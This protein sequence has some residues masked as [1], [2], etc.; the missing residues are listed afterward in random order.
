MVFIGVPMFAPFVGQGL[1]LLSGWRT[2]FFSL[3]VFSVVT[4]IWFWL[5]QPETLAP[6]NKRSLEFSKIILTLK[7]V[8]AHPVSL[9][10]L[11]IIGLLAGTVSCC[12][13]F[14][15]G[16]TT[17]IAMEP[18]GHIAGGAS[19]IINSLSTLIAI[20]VAT[21]IGSHITNTGHPVVIGYMCASVVALSLSYSAKRTPV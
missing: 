9:R 17:S 14:L 16:N 21:M 13:A 20:L 15:F 3:C 1:L 2:I 5:R 12:F 10:Y 11:V 8:L 18:M 7:E 19:S 6:D 4:M